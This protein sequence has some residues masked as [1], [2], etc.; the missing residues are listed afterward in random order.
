[1][2]RINLY[3]NRWRVAGEHGRFAGTVDIHVAAS[4]RDDFVTKMLAELRAIAAD[5]EGE[6]ACLVEHDTRSDK[7]RNGDPA[8]PGVE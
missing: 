4:S 7:D 2:S 8:R 5:L 6:R 1:M 3:E